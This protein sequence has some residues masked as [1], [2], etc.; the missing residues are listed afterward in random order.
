MGA[1]CLAMKALGE[2]QPR[3]ARIDDE[4][5]QRVCTELVLPFL[6][7]ERVLLRCLAIETLGR[8]AQAVAKPQVLHEALIITIL[9]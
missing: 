7:S 5:L 1:V 4:N 8:L 3:G 2:T 6:N 9:F